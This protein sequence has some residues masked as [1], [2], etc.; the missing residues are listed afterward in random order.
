MLTERR[1]RILELRN[2]ECPF[3]KEETGAQRNSVTYLKSIQCSQYSLSLD[4][5]TSWFSVLSTENPSSH[6]LKNKTMKQFEKLGNFSPSPTAHNYNFPIA[7][8]I[9]F[10][11]LFPT[12]LYFHI[13]NITII[14]TIC[15]SD[16]LK[17]KTFFTISVI[18]MSIHISLLNAYRDTRYCSI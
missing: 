11:Y 2:S 18:H 1:V 3:P 14:I 8:I 6:L 12:Y 16:F 17:Q 5:W 15:V 10:V 7:F 4:L 13:F 9:V